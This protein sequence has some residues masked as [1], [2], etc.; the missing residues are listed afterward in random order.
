MHSFSYNASI[1]EFR[2]KYGRNVLVTPSTVHDT[3]V[4]TGPTRLS[5]PQQRTPDKTDLFVGRHLARSP[6]EF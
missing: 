4:P 1:K 2:R 6:G 5:V 3:G